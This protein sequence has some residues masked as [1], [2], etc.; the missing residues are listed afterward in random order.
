M[1]C[2]ERHVNI[3][4][5]EWLHKNDRKLFTIV[6]LFDGKHI[7][8][9]PTLYNDIKFIINCLNEQKINTYVTTNGSMLSAKADI[10]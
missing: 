2:Y 7:G 5:T 4:R 6:E 8:G 10:S 3:F 9:E 1:A